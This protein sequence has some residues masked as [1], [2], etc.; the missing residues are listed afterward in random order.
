MIRAATPKDILDMVGWLLTSLLIGA[1]AGRIAKY[2]GAPIELRFLAFV[3]LTALAMVIWH[4]GRQFE[5][6]A[7]RA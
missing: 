6:K 3:A 1:L 5:A 2:F 7:D 4:V